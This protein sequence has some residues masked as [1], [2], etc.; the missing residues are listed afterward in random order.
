MN[1]RLTSCSRKKLRMSRLAPTMSTR[2]KAISATTSTPRNRCALPEPC[3][4]SLSVCC[5]SSLA[6]PN[7][8]A[9]PNANPARQEIPSVKASTDESMLT[10]SRRGIVSGFMSFKIRIPN[11]ASNRPSVPPTSASTTLSVRSWRMSRRALAPRAA[12]E[13]ISFS[14]TADRASSR[15]ATFTHAISRTKATAA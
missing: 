8:G 7:A 4:P 3:P 15:L 13:A 5:T 9:N 1:P 6:N 11:V 10:S 14:R 2:D 12:R